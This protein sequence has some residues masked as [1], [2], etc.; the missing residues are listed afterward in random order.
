MVIWGWTD[1][2][3]EKE[4]FA[5]S[6]RLEAYTHLLGTVKW[7]ICITL[8]VSFNTSARHACL[9]W[10]LLEQ[11]HIFW[12]AS[13]SLP[14]PLH[15]KNVS[16]RDRQCV[17][18]LPPPFF[19]RLS[20][21][22]L[23]T[24]H[25]FSFTVQ[26]NRKRIKQ[27]R[28]KHLSDPTLTVWQLHHFSVARSSSSKSWWMGDLPDQFGI[29]AGILQVLEMMMQDT[30]MQ[31]QLKSIKPE[32]LASALRG[33]RE[34]EAGPWTILQNISRSG[35]PEIL[36]LWRGAAPA[37]GG[38]LGSAPGEFILEQPGAHKWRVP[39]GAKAESLSS[40]SGICASHFRSFTVLGI[41]ALYFPS[42]WGAVY[43]SMPI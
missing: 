40:C 29:T 9:V 42:W 19:P 6:H 2:Q 3:H 23:H 24:Q 18:S 21:L 10:T 7:C 32:L 4:R 17:F 11:P 43:K 36:L 8:I 20:I 22:V 31:N 26:P 15:L 16:R 13:L 33:G 39:A 1:T 35:V 5:G 38:S 37:R 12:Q 27:K 28:S 41:P 30:W 34:V 25:C 14:V